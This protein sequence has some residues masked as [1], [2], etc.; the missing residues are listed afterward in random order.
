MIDCFI[1][2]LIQKKIGRSGKYLKA[3]STRFY[4]EGYGRGEP[5]MMFHGGLSTLETF[6][7]QVPELSKYYHLIL[8]ER[9]GHGHTPDT[10]GPYSYKQMAEDMAS[11]MNFRGVKKAK[12]IGY[13]DGANLIFHLALQHPELIESCVLIGGNFHYEGSTAEHLQELRTLTDETMRLQG[14]RN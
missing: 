10:P 13:S 2:S 11:F 14:V 9:R 6:R 1:T 8:P 5:L 7:F 3:N 12:M 4:Y